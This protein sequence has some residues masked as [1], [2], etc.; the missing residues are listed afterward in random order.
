MQSVSSRIWTR[1]AVTNSYDDNHYTTGTYI[2]MLS[3]KHGGI[4]YHFWSLWYD[5][6][7]DWT[8]LSRDIGKQSIH[9]VNALV[10]NSNHS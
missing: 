3:D 1:V 8:L 4:K 7:W 2:I 5:S 10:S 6:T 9:K